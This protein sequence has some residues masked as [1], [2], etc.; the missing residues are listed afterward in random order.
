MGVENCPRV[1]NTDV[2]DVTFFDISVFLMRIHT[3]TTQGLGK[4]ELFVFSSSKRYNISMFE[5]LFKNREKRGTGEIRMGDLSA[6]IIEVR[7]TLRGLIEANPQVSDVIQAYLETERTRGY[8]EMNADLE[9]FEGAL[10]SAQEMFRSAQERFDT[11]M[12][13]QD[14]GDIVAIIQAEEER[15]KQVA[16]QCGNSDPKDLALK[17]I[18]SVLIG[19]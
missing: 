1:G 14:N 2:A 7:Q 17:N 3:T 10:S 19:D 4:I 18:G 11:L 13:N 9:L 8:V 12:Q 16:I 15:L 6:T 5:R